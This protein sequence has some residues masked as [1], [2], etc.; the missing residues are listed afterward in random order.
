MKKEKI[1]II[2]AGGQLGSELTQALWAQHGKENVIATDIKEPQ[3]VLASGHFEILNVLD[4]QQ[5]S[6]LI[7]KNG[8]TQIYLLAAVLSA[9]GEK[10]PRLAWQLN[11]DGL[12][13]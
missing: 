12:I 8:F 3:G 10:N 1:L 5:L 9:T 4:Q 6:G 13:S 11:M 7:K 2:G